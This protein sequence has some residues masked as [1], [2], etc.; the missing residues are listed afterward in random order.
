V[1]IVFHSL[2]PLT[3]DGVPSLG[4]NL[5]ILSAIHLQLASCCSTGGMLLWFKWSDLLLLGGSLAM[6]HRPISRGWS[7]TMANSHFGF[8]PTL[9]AV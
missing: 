1:W 2:F 9:T 6:L 7:G 8:L 4:R 3:F 5:F